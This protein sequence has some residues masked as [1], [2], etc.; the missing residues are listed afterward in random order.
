M[1]TKNKKVDKYYDDFLSEQIKTDLNSRHRN[2]LH[3]LKKTGLKR[4]HHI[5]EVGCG[6][7]IISGVL[8]NYLRKGKV[9]G[10][11]ISP[12]SIRF[13]SEKYKKNKN[14]KFYN[15]DIANFSLQEKFDY[16]IMP[17][18]LEHIPKETYNE[19]F[20]KLYQMLKD[21]G[22]LYIH[23]PSGTYNQYIIDHEPEKLQIIDHALDANMIIVPAEISGFELVNYSLYCLYTSVGDYVNIF[24]R[25]KSPQY[26]K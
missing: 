5:L 22:R 7:G 16:I 11:D 9:S 21:D 25:K 2:I 6:I 14:L 8:A 17:D 4:H 23:I 3:Y 19:V 13:A 10:C 24:F 20:Q 18:V 12:E 1:Q 26:C 15:S